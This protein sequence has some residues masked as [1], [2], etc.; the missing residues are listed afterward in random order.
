MLR[1]IFPNICFPQNSIGMYNC[2]YR[3]TVHDLSSKML[4]I[5]TFLLPSGS[6]SGG[7]ETIFW[8]SQK[9]LQLIRIRRKKKLRENKE[10]NST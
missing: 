1:T 8:D 9:F 2:K 10:Q 3:P 7:G 4:N 6:Q 5:E